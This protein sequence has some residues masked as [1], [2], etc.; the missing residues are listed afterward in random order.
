MTDYSKMSGKDLAKLIGG[1]PELGDLRDEIA[2]RL[3]AGDGPLRMWS[4]IQAAA[5]QLLREA[6]TSWGQ[7]PPHPS[8]GTFMGEFA[9][10]AM[11]SAI[12]V[13]EQ[14]AALDPRALPGSAE[15]R[16]VDLPQ[17]AEAHKKLREAVA[18]AQRPVYTTEQ[19]DPRV[20]WLV[21]RVERMERQL[22]DLREGHNAH[23]HGTDG[24]P[25]G[26]SNWHVH[27]DPADNG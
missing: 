10:P 20:S 26:R 5:V 3:E 24:A 6:L 15:L 25:T 18:A 13:L 17:Y 1:Y 19:L 12:A 2:R 8:P 9:I 4:P 21:A 16:E 23:R 22:A 27:E 7:Q 14:G 11:E